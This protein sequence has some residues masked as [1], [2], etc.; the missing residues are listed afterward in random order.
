MVIGRPLVRTISGTA[1]MWLQ[2]TAELR[3]AWTGEGARPHTTRNPNLPAAVSWRNHSSI[4]T[5]TRDAIE[6][7]PR[8]QRNIADG[9]FSVTL[10]MQVGRHDA[11]N[12]RPLVDED[13]AGIIAHTFELAGLVGDLQIVGEIARDKTVFVGGEDLE[14]I[15]GH[16]LVQNLAAVERFEQLRHLAGRGDIFAAFGG[17][18]HIHHLAAQAGIAQSLRVQEGIHV[19]HADAVDEDVGGGVV[20]DGDHH[21]RKV[22]QRDPGDTRREAAHDVAVLDEIGGVDG[23]K[24]RKLQFALLG[25]PVKFGE[26]ADLDELAWGKTSLA[27]S[28]YLVAV[29]EIDDG[30]SHDAVETAVD[31]KNRFLKLR[32]EDLLFLSGRRW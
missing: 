32:P 19:L 7:S 24:V 29:G 21:G 26:D 30:Y 27:C 5:G 28:R 4:L 3:S 9:L 2:A 15:G 20:A 14:E 31:V 10:A 6:H 11:E 16:L 1:S 23:V 17:G 25:L 12:V 22:A 18:F 8:G 13:Q